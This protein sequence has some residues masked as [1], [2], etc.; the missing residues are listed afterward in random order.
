MTPDHAYVIFMIV[1]RFHVHARCSIAEVETV[2]A[3][4]RKP[5]SSLVLRDLD[6]FLLGFAQHLAYS[7]NEF[8]PNLLYALSVWFKL[9]LPAYECI[10][11]YA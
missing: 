8:T 10:H 2:P 1:I 5:R 4:L 7:P 11:V 6:N 9:I 3:P